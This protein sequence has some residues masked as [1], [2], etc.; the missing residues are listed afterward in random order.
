MFKINNED[1]RTL[2]KT[3]LYFTPFS[4]VFTDDYEQI[5]VCWDFMKNLI[6]IFIYC[7]TMYLKLIQH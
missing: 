7:Y 2:S 4:S 6:Q 5:N 1:V 3:S